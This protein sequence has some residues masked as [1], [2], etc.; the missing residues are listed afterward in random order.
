MTYRFKV[1]PIKILSIFFFF[2]EIRRK[3]SEIHM[4][5]QGTPNSQGN[6]EKEQR[7]THSTWRQN[8]SQSYSNQNSVVHEKCPLL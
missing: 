8:L 1:I 3:D 2:V 5:K 6:L 7:M 4:E